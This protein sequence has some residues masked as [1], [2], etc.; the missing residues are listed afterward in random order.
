MQKIAK[1]SLSLSPCGGLY[2]YISIGWLWDPLDPFW[3]GLWRTIG[4]ASFLVAILAT[5]PLFHF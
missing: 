1:K 2:W 3:S 5:G 4:I